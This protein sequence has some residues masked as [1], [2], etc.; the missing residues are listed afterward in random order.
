ML[1]GKAETGTGTE[2]IGIWRIWPWR[3]A[4]LRCRVLELRL[5]LLLLAG[6][7]GDPLLKLP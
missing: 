7:L 3:R 2:R 4:R 1:L 6:L 5:S